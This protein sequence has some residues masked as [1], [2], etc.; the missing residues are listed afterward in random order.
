MNAAVPTPSQYPEP[1]QQ[2][3]RVKAL[4][5]NAGQSKLDHDDDSHKTFGQLCLGTVSPR[6]CQY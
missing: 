1:L 6:R 5:L 4:G 2:T 3:P